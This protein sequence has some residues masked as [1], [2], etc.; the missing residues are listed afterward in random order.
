MKK[1]VIIFGASGNLGKNIAPILKKN[2]LIINPKSSECNLKKQIS[3]INF[4]KSIPNEKYVIIYLA[5]NV[6]KN[7]NNLNNYKTNLLMM[8]NLL[9]ICNSYYI[10]KF[11]YFSTIDIYKKYNIK[12]LI[13]ERS[14]KTPDT[15][16]AKSKMIDENLLVNKISRDKLLIFR[17]PGVYGPKLN[18]FLNSLKNNFIQNKPVKIYNYGRNY[19]DFLYIK[20]IVK[21]ISIFLTTNSVG[22]YNISS[23]KSFM[24]NEIIK[25]FQKKFRSKSKITYLK[26]RNE[27][28]DY[29][30]FISNSKILKKLN[31]FKFTNIENGINNL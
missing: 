15:L 7:K 14:K 8:K 30:L 25:I 13:F 29:N 31:N 6:S 17:I 23:G 3:I 21:I 24:I 26:K 9:K 10:D 11:I 4:F 1:K 12:K 5:T 22:T 18:S 28:S 19:R 2:N 16:Y 27:S 20:D